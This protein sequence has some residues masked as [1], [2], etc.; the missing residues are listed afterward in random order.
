MDKNELRIKN[1]AKFE[2]QKARLE[3]IQ[4]KIG[5]IRLN[6]NLCCELGTIIVLF[7]GALFIKGPDAFTP[8]LLASGCLNLGL[9]IGLT[10]HINDLKE[11][12]H[13]IEEELEDYAEDIKSHKISADNSKAKTFANRTNH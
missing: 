2:L 12:Q 5:T 10:R 6:R 9:G 1:A 13:D 11:E 4:T 8:F 3:K 7:S